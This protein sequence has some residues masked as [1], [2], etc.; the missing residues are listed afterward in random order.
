MLFTFPSRYC[1]T[2]GHLSCSALD[3]GRPE[4]N[5][6]FTC[7]GLLRVLAQA[8]TRFSPTGLSPSAAGFPNTVQLILSFVTAWKGRNSSQQNP[9]TPRYATLAGLHV[10]GLGSYPLSLTTT[11]GISFDFFYIRL[12]RCFTSPASPL[13]KQVSGLRRRGCPIRIPSD[14]GLLAPPR[15]FSQL[16]ASFF[17]DKCQGILSVPLTLYSPSCLCLLFLCQ[18][19]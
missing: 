6:N 14:L 10:C 3:H 17:A 12:L 9:I 15:S 7:S 11:E 16:T 5:R 13:S 1:F 18:I 19:T 2:I 4:F 8:G